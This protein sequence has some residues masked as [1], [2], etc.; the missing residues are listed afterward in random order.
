MGEILARY[1]DGRLFV[2]EEKLA[3]EDYTNLLPVRV[4]HVKTVEQVISVDAHMSGY[5]QNP[6]LAPLKDAAVSGDKVNVKLY[7]ADIEQVTVPLSG[8]VGFLSAYP[9]H[10]VLSGTT[11]GIGFHADLLSGVAWVS[12]RVN[13]ILNVIGY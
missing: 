11:S 9:G 2:R 13:V 7:K 1:A 3:E 12:G 6:L 5:P 4:G 8:Y 10:S